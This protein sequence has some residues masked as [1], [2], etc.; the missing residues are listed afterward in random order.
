MKARFSKLLRFL[1][2]LCLVVWVMGPAAVAQ[3]PP[4]L[5]A[6][7]YAGLS[8]TG[9][10]GTV[11]SVEYVTDLA[12]TNNAS[13]WQCLEYLQLP[14]SP[15]LWAD[16]SAPAI[17]KRFYRAVQ[18]PAPTNL[19]FIPPGKFRMGSPTNEVDRFGDEGP[20]TE[21]TISLGFW[22]GKCEVTQGK[23]L[24]VMGSNPSS[25]AGDTNRPVES[26]SWQDATAYCAALTQRERLAGRIATNSV[27]RLPT[28]AEW[29]YACRAGTTVRFSYGDDPG[30]TNLMN[31][32][33]YGDNS[34][35]T[36]H[37]VGQKLPNP[38][39]LYDM[40]GNVWEWCQDRYGDYAGGIAVDP[41]GLATG[42][43]RLLRGGYWGAGGDY[44]RFCRSAHRGN[45]DPAA[46]TST[47]G[48]RIVLAP[49]QP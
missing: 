20:Q 9:V 15:Y 38:W 7:L 5:N 26:V 11:Y 17:G 41:Q 12:Q 14:A 18:F 35:D 1:S 13:A 31:Y 2:L 36:T 24:A 8:I 28:E 3:T 29:E 32:A 22:L 25:F 19:V 6:Q 21:V 27:Y 16:K 49:G 47:F 43:D 42:S 39:G 10:V 33:W 40:H 46:G 4:V 23:Y 30:Y 48:F 44:A 37:P 45:Y 34:G